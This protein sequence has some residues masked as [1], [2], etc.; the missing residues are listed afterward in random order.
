MYL[1][2]IDK[3]LEFKQF[4]LFKILDEIGSQQSFLLA[5]DKLPNCSINSITTL[6]VVIPPC[7][8]LLNV[9]LSLFES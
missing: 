3:I 6:D 1:L 2:I 9:L 8:A 5:G 4:L 7:Y